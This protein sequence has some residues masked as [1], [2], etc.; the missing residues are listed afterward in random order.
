ME[1]SSRGNL[2]SDLAS[3]EPVLREGDGNGVRLLIIDS[4]VEAQHPDLVEAPVTCFGIHGNG[5]IA[6]E[7]GFDVFGHGTGVASVLRSMVPHAELHSLRTLDEK[8]KASPETTLKALEWAIDQGYPIVNCSF[9]TSLELW[10]PAFK[11]LVD[12][13]YRSNT[14]L[15]GTANNFNSRRAVYPAHFPA[16]FAVTHG[17]M[18][19]PWSLERLPGELV[20]YRARGENVH[21]AWKDGSHQSVT[22][23]SYAAPHLAALLVRLR[24]ANPDMSIVKAKAVLERLLPVGRIKTRGS[25]HECLF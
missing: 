8:L 23:S 5:Q 20:E 10:L 22:G 3:F 13:A 24:E 14:W 19:D 21:V 7:L 11:R 12:A 17:A 18:E 16:V 25:C 2:S 9:G 4:G 6:E 1:T 15:V